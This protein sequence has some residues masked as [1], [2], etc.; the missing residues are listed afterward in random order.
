ME[1]EDILTPYT[2]V[3]N[4]AHFLGFA[5]FKYSTTEN[6][7]VNLPISKSWVLIKISFPLLQAAF[8]VGQ[9]IYFIFI[10]HGA[11]FLRRLQ[12]TY[13]AA[14]YSIF[15]VQFVPVFYHEAATPAVMNNLLKLTGALKGELGQS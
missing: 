1:T 4:L 11:S 9:A 3:A 12:L 10:K 8:L 5:P 13:Y 14:G 7:L 2:R 15:V 6:I